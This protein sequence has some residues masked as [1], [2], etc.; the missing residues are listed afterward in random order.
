[1]AAG[2]L[3]VTELLDRYRANQDKFK[4]FIVKTVTSMTEDITDV[5][6]DGTASHSLYENK[7]EIELRYED[8]DD[9]R[10]YM[11]PKPI[12][13]ASDESLVYHRYLWVGE[14]YIEHHKGPTVDESN[15]YI[16]S[17][18]Q[19]IKD[20]I[21]IGYLGP[22]SFLGW[23]YGDVEPFDSILKKA[24]SISVR[25]ERERVGSGECYVIDANTKHGTY[26]IWLDPEHGYGIAKANIHKGPKDL[27]FGRPLEYYMFAPYDISIRNVR[28]ESIEGVWIPMEA[29]FLA[30]FKGDHKGSSKVSVRKV[31]Q[32][33]TEL[34][35]NPDHD[36]LGSFV[37]DIENGTQARILE[38]PEINYTWQDGKLVSQIDEYVIDEIDRITE[39]MASPEPATEIKT[40]VAPNDLTGSA[41]T[42]PKTQ[43]DTVKT[44]PEVIAESDSF[45]LVPVILVSVLI[46]GVIGWLVFT[47]VRS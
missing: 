8:G 5:N 40:G 35:L 19:Y 21:A 43:I 34:L 36:A 7:W 14:R 20:N 41:S 33:V 31:H 39:G 44:R 32:R 4:S 30:D 42:Q 25:S 29:D 1:V 24:N 17:D 13:S 22:G 46:I 28:F 9:F 15:S 27:R 26:T 16:S 45:P 10:A 11:C 3:S 12:Q 47:R 37:P 2:Q 38:V 18:K 6:K 23:L